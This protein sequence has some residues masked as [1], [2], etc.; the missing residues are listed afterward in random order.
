MQDTRPE[1]A[2]PIDG[3]WIAGVCAGLAVHLG[4]DVRLVRVGAILLALA[5][6]GILAYL[7]LWIF[8]PSAPARG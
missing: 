6:I 7:L 4:V 1:L 5:G 2:R 3:R 8:V